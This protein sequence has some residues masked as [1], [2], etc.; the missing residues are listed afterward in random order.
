MR[1]R[2]VPGGRLQGTVHV[3][4]DKSIAHRWLILASTASSLSRLTG[5]PGA[6]DVRSTASCLADLTVKARPALDLWARNA[7]SWVEGSG[8]TWNDTLGEVPNGTLEVEGEGRDGLVEPEGGLGCGNSGTSMRLL[9]GLIA[10]APFTTELTGDPSL[11]A[12][13]MERVASP[14]RT[15]GAT[16]RTTDGHAPLVVTGGRLVGIEHRTE[17]PSAQVKGALLFAGVRASGETFVVESAPTRDHT[18]RAFEALGAPVRREGLRVGIA[19]F[20][21]EGFDAAIPGDPSSAAF[22]IAAAALTGSEVTV[23]GVGLNP[24]RLHFLEVLSRMGVVTETSVTGEELG[25]PVGSIHVEPTAALRSTRV[26]ADELPLVIDEVPVLAMLATHA[27]AEARFLGASELRV[28]ESDRLTALAEGIRT[29]GGHAT[30]KAD[31]LVIA[32]G[33]LRG[34]VASSGGDHRLAMAFAVGSL[35]ADRPSEVE[36]MEAA[37]VSFPGFVETLRSIGAAIEVTG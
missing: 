36:G 34:G 6:F 32:G 15:M 25:E 3:G 24:T 30:A 8:S 37:A 12:R 1:I 4:G 22:V 2:V 35:A 26:E 10:A 13:P 31:D 23:E 9:A 17:V 7:S 18:E 29:L 14:L 5:L 21:H 19:W 27:P 20:Q 33:G 11:S 16:V 28:K